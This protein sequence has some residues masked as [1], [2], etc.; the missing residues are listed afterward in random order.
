MSYLQPKP[1]GQL[2]KKDTKARMKALRL[3]I[4]LFTAITIF[5]CLIIL[6]ATIHSYFFFYRHKRPILKTNKNEF[7][8]YEFVR[9][10][11]DHPPK[12][13]SEDKLF[14]T[15][16]KNGAPVISVGGLKALLLHYNNKLH[17]FEGKWPIPWNAPDGDYTANLVIPRPHKEPLEFST[18]FTISRKKPTAIPPGPGILTLES[19]SYLKNAKIKDP[20]G[21]TGNWE[22]I[23]SWAEYLTADTVWYLAGQTASWGEKIENTFPWVK[24]NVEFT[25]LFA[26]TARLKGYKFG[27][28]VACYLTFGDQTKKADYSYAYNYDSTKGT[29]VPTRSVS[30]GDLKRRE[31]I[32]KLLKY[33][34]SIPEVDYIGVDYI[35]NAIGG[36][37]MIDQFVADMNPELPV[38]WSSYDKMARMCWLGKEIQRRQKMKLVDQWNWW[39]AQYVANIVKEIKAKLNTKKPLWCFT[40]SWQKGWQHGQDPVMMNDAGADLDAVMLYECDRTQ[41]NDLIRDWNRYVGTNQV[42]LLG[43]DVVDFNLHQKS[44]NPATPDE[45][46]NRMVTAHQQMSGEGRIKGLFWHDLARGLWGRVG[47]YSINEWA[48][49]GGAAFS[50]LRHDWKLLEMESTLEI[51]AKLLSQHEYPVQVKIKNISAKTLKNIK[52]KFLPTPYM[53]CSSSSEVNVQELP[54]KTE[55]TI[56]F[57]IKISGSDAG[58]AYLNMLAFNCNW[59]SEKPYHTLL[60]FRYV[61]VK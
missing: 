56:P 43:G 46:Y 54:Q 32:L 51:P 40:L 39:R 6:V 30:I 10:I 16:A 23:F 45:L 4:H 24:N 48:I 41:Y 9:F 42:N 33:L 18:L 26:K 1:I 7:L 49:A 5:V 36:Y 37:E 50:A 55:K 17:Q 19:T 20:N 3:P 58:R 52:I 47:P 28:W 22:N 57:L 53:H 21:Y 44:T 27:A 15:I 35:R 8:H 34:A 61:K 59:E 14:V 2:K 38:A 29:C 31:D 25:P 13:N 11:F 60:K 12:L